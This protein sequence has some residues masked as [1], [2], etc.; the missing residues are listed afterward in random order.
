[1]ITA[2]FLG[3]SQTYVPDDNFEQALIDLG[4]DSG[5][6][7]DYVP[8]ANI[9]GV[10]NLDVNS[11]NIA[12]LTGIEDFLSLQTLNCETNS[13]SV[14]NVSK[15]TALVQ[16]FCGSNSLATIDISKLIDLQIFW[17][18]DNQLSNL[19]VTNNSNLISIVCGN[20]LLSNLDISKNTALNVLSFENNQ[21]R[22]INVSNNN[23]LNLLN[24][25]NNL[26]TNLNIANN[27]MLSY[28]NCNY[29]QINVLDLSNNNLLIT[30]TLKN[31]FLT[32]LDVSQNK[33]VTE[34][35]C[36]DNLLCALNLK[37]GNNANLAVCDFSNNPELN[38]VVVDN[39][40]SNHTSWTPSMFSNYVSSQSDCSSFVN[41]DTLNNVI[42][43]SYT[44]PP[45]TY[46]NYFTASG[47]LGIPLFPGDLITSSQT[48]YIY[49][50][51]GCNSN[52]SSFRVLIQDGDYYIPK[53]FTPN[54]DGDHDF[55]QVLDANN[56]IKY[57]AIYNRYGKLI[58]YIL[59]NTLGWNG[60]FNGKA[61]ETNDYWYVITLNSGDTLKGHFTLKR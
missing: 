38:C 24:G 51:T 22:S 21:I 14:L 32:E 28:L 60:T 54:N 10:V 8:T 4:Y 29:N 47:G 41:V 57:I 30:I 48:I 6:L 52:E 16:L 45:L 12:D 35:D 33:L 31:N 17:C 46:G 5:P 61:L 27:G 2:S 43:T 59:P 53:Y 1:M 11:K 9:V 25:S 7:D 23:T 49:N 3:W 56:T 34:I 20:N 15:N 55:W 13:L 19:D 42:G 26:L 37:N 18:Q 58:K 36:S 44:L 40:S 50:Q 39:P